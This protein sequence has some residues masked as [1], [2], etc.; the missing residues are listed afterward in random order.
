M[1]NAVSWLF[2]VS[3]APYTHGL[4]SDPALDMILAAGAFGQ[5]VSVVFTSAGVDYLSPHLVPK[6]GETDMRKVLKSLPFYD[7]EKVYA[8][9]QS[10]NSSMTES[11]IPHDIIDR[12]TATSLIASADH[13][14]TF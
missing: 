11:V 10:S 1:D 9:G 8:V 5:T 2:L 4:D 13:V 12:E 7:I 14:V 6:E 3:S